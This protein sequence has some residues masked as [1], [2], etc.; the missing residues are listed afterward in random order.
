VSLAIHGF[1]SSHRGD[2]AGTPVEGDALVCQGGVIA[3]IGDSAELDPA[4]HE[5]VID[6]NGTGLIPGLI[7]SHV[8]VT[9]GDYSPRQQVVGFLESTVHGGVTSVISASEVHVPGRPTD[10]VGVKA[11]AVAAQRCFAEYRPGGMKVYAGSVIL[12]PGL[13]DEDF[14]DL[15]AAGVWLAKAGFGAV[16]DAFGYVPLVRAAREAGLVV[17]CHTGGGSIPGSLDRIDAAALLAMAPDICGH[18]NGGPTA[19]TPEDAERLVR[20]GRMALQLAT[21]G[22]LPMAVR[23]ATLAVEIGEAERLLISTDTPTGTGTMPLGM[24]H[25]MAELAGLGALT[26]DG[27]VTAATGNVAAVYRLPSGR[28]ELGA[29]ADLVLVDAPLG[30][31]GDDWRQALS[32]G[33]MPAVAAVATAGEIRVGRSRNTPVPKRMAHFTDQKRRVLA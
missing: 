10:P 5:V 11:L 14:A 17:M 7:D 4:D 29:P 18:V 31:V 32:I 3:W 22:N 15:S 19:T 30:S 28:L 24:L 27:V 26:P 1:G 12:E 9:F 33:D 21:A 6:A 2:L 25:L 8:H 16:E 23:I 13:S 20:E